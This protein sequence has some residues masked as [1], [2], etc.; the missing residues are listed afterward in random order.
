M[1]ITR[2]GSA[3]WK[4]GIKDGQGSLTTG[5]GELGEVTYSAGM[6]FGEDAGTNPEELIAAALAGCFA[7]ALSA[8]LSG[9]GHTAEELRTTARASIERTDAGWRYTG[10]ALELSAKVPG[11]SR[12]DFMK[13]AEAAKNG[14]PVSN[15]LKTD[16]TLKAELA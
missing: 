7:M 11:I 15:V 2:T 6:R 10:I 8:A 13:H 12:D 4:G 16:I 9:A 3:V 14:C 5:S 1:A